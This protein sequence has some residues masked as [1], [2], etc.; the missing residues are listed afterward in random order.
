[1]NRFFAYALRKAAL[2]AGKPGRLL[3]LL[4]QMALKLK[5]VNLKGANF[6]SA[7]EK[8]AVLG[9]LI[10]AYALGQYRDVEWKTILFIL[11]AIIYFINPID[12]LPD[13][14]PV[15]GFTDDFGVLL[16]VYNSVSGEINKFLTWEKSQVI[17]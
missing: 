4:S 2:T 6:S 10:K 9:R 7:A 14:L 15:T 11:G 16:W 12:L 8:F 1:M 17:S 13:M 3:F 5:D